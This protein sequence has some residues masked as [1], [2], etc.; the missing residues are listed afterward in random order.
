MRHLLCLPNHQ[1]HRVEHT[2]VLLTVIPMRHQ[3]RLEPPELHIKRSQY[4][5]HLEIHPLHLLR[6]IQLL[7]RLPATP[8]L[9]LL[10]QK[11]ILLIVVLISHLR[12]HGFGTLVDYPSYVSYDG[13][14]GL[15]GGFG[16]LYLSVF[17][18]EVGEGAQAEGLAVESTAYNIQCTLAIS[19]HS[20]D[21][22]R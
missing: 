14:L 7:Q 3:H 19:P 13:V 17:R 9:V 15:L 4:I 10:Q 12:L 21:S 16:E 1:V 18:V 5:K 6:T 22:C 8:I 20:I 2:V 11:P